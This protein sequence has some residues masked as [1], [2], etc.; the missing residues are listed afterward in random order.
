MSSELAVS[1][2]AAPVSSSAPS[3]QS[4][5]KR[6]SSSREGVAR[7]CETSERP[8]IRR[9]SSSAAAA[10]LSLSSEEA[11][12]RSE[13]AARRVAGGLSPPRKGE[14]LSSIAPACGAASG[15]SAGLAAMFASPRSAMSGAAFSAAAAEPGASSAVSRRAIGGSRVS[16]PLLAARSS[17]SLSKSSAG[18]RYG[19][20][21]PSRPGRPPSPVKVA[22]VAGARARAAEA[23][24]LRSSATSAARPLS[25]VSSSARSGPSPSRSLAEN[26][27]S[28]ARAASCL[29]ASN[30]T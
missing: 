10:A 27:S 7:A 4:T 12:R 9:P 19:A 16:T 20:G 3:E 29:P 28:L 18:K 1:A 6:A 23:P 14:R 17:A 26:S 24:P 11:L 21:Q 22:R 5:R 13:L 30:E 25:W 8:C 2:A 15:R